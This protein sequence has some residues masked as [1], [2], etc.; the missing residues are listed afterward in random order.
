[1]RIVMMGMWST[2]LRMN[3]WLLGIHLTFKLNKIM[4]SNKGRTSSI[5]D[6]IF[7]TR[8]AVWSLMVVVVLMLLVLLLLWSWI[9][10]LLNIINLIDYNSWI[11]MENLKL[12]SKSWFCFLL[13]GIMMKCCVIWFICMWVTCCW[14][15][16]GNSIWKNAWWF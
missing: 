4:W 15:V 11:N 16:H 9:W 3:I 1:L 8:Y 10:T 5:R 14:V 6:A 7:V 13:E 2:R 12:Q